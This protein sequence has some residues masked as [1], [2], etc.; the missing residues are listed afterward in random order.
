MT[1]LKMLV[2]IVVL[3]GCASGPQDSRE[4][5]QGKIRIV[6]PVTQLP[7]APAI[8]DGGTLAVP[9]RDAKGKEFTLFIDHRMESPTPGTIYLNAYPGER[10]SVR[11]HETAEFKRKVGDFDY[12]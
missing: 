8:S 6:A 5:V 9:I 11:V 1:P 7:R 4:F 3:G 12:H 10:G 2:L